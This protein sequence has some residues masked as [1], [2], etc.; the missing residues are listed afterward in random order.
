[1]T[2]SGSDIQVGDLAAPVITAESFVTLHYRIILAS[3][4]EVMVSTFE[5]SPATLQMGQ[6]QLAEGLESC[7]LGLRTGQRQV[8]ELPPARAYGDKQTALFRPVSKKTLEQH[9][10]A[11]TTF[12]PG[13][14]VHFP[15]PNGGQFAGTVVRVDEDT[16]LFDFN[17]PLSG[18]ALKFEVQVIG[19]L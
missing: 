10:E 19:V 14:F 16:V 13:D 4:D 6:G 8:F 1:M 7:L 5:E 12:E 11:D 9:A 18:Q 3:T 2:I 17:H 15:A